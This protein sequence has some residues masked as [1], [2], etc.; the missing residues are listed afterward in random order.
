M[1]YEIVDTELTGKSAAIYSIVPVGEKVS[2]F[3]KF[4]KEWKDEFPDEVNEI[5]ERLRL[6]GDKL[7]AREG[8]FKHNEG[9][10]GDGVC[11]FYD[12]PG[13]KLRVYCIR[14][15]NVAIILGGG[16]P[17]SVKAWQDDVKLNAEARKIIAYARDINDR[18]KH[19]DLYWSKS[20]KELL[21]NLNNTEN[22]D[23]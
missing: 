11:A 12:V 18:L 2:V 10:P 21:G 1:E 14:Y 6:I 3:A 16:G 19:D 17:K 20:G 22:E 13:A 8:F 7:G 23:E 15:G 5:V 9:K 4:L